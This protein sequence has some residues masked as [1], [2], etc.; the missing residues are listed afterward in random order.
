MRQ[1]HTYVPK[2]IEGSTFIYQVCT[3][4]PVLCDTL[5]YDHG[6]GQR[7][8]DNIITMIISPTPDGYND[9]CIIENI[10]TG[11]NEVLIINRWG[12]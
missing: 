6:Y 11:H 10:S 3:T 5:S 9:T 2:R 4:A 12:G 8:F 1:Y 7:P